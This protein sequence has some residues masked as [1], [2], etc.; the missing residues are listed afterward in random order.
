[1]L[2]RLSLTNYLLIE[3]LELDL[4]D[5][6]T[7][8]TGE[9]GSGKSILIGAL[10]LVLGDRAD[11]GLAR[12]PAK[13]CIIEME[14]DLQGPGMEAWCEVAGVP[15][16][17]R[18][19]I[20]R[21][22]DPGGRSRA[23]INDTPVRLE[24]LRELGERLVHVHSQHQAQLL[25]D[26]Q[27][28]LGL[29][30]QTA[31]HL[32]TVAAYRSE[33]KAWQTL[34]TALAQARDEE[35]R[36][37]TEQDFLL[38]QLEE[39]D[40]AQ[41]KD[42]EQ[43]SLE[44]DLQRAEH[45]G[46][47]L[48]ALQRTGTTISGEEG[49]VSALAALKH[50]LARTARHDPGVS[51]LLDRLNSTGIELQDIADEAAKQAIR[52]QLDP[53]EADRMRERLDLLLRLQQKHRV[54]ENGGLIALR[55]D[56]R[57]R[58]ARVASLADRIIEMEGEERIAHERIVVLAESISVARR[59]AM[60]ALAAEVARQLQQ[61]GMPHARFTFDHKTTEAGPQGI[62]RIRVLF[63]ANKD[64]SPEALDKVASG[65]EL[66]RV[67][68]ALISL[69]AGSLG[70]PALVFDEIDT[71][72]SGEVADRVGLLMKQ[73]AR[74]H[75][76]IA[77]THLPQIASKGDAHLLVTKDHE[78]EAVTST[79]RPLN[80]EERVQVLAQMLSGRKTSKA[81]VENARELLKKR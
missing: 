15:F 37:R 23:F 20:R 65:G 62:D 45:A 8:I 78:A 22:L 79:I 24:Q 57:M 33:Y 74:Q 44:L 72:V 56:L 35:A 32:K 58:A 66:G 75:Q 4:G 41:L 11:N 68:L 71:G 47:I 63:S 1:M 30:D 14:A 73:M 55:E 25:H 31:G 19:I 50:H 26:P 52:V 53:K 48:E 43:E 77:I 40:Q 60:P 81:A 49:L 12:D 9:T 70:L 54:K 64:R 18:S 5:G 38:F 2:R 34:A 61:L 17:P 10:G 80:S 3:E 51:A 28:Q 13:R 69:S 76:V 59:N 46:G 21:Q 6:L 67:M 27:F 7:I 42:G 16:E 29:V 39:L 36:S